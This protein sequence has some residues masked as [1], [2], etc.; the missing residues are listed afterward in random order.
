MHVKGT[1]ILCLHH[2]VFLTSSY[3]F[4]MLLLAMFWKLTIVLLKLSLWFETAV[5]QFESS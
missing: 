1:V 2:Y 4:K 3:I 5:K